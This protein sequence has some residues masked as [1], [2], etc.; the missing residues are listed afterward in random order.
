MLLTEA[1]T[2]SAFVTEIVH[3]IGSWRA[4]SPL[5]ATQAISSV[6]LLEGGVCELDS[7]I[8]DKLW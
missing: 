7:K 3:T 2:G 4:K 8:T 6:E 5:E 1:D